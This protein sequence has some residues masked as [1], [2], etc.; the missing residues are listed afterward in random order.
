MQRTLIVSDSGP[1]IAL[2]QL[3]CLELLPRLFSDI[4]IPPSV[5]RELLSVGIPDWLTVRKP[6]AIPPEI[7]ALELGA[8]ETEALALAIESNA[9]LL[10]DEKEGR[11]ASIRFGLTTRGTV[12]L[13]LLARQERLIPA[14]KPLLQTLRDQHHFWIHKTILEMALREA[15]EA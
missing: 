8:G 5:E 12:G 15:G 9:E 7:G 14:V 1:L 3:G 10:I 13:L 2:S 4:A 11:R 6:S